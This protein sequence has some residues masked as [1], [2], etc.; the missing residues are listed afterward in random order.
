MD[1]GKHYRENKLLSR[2]ISLGMSLLLL[3][4]PPFERNPQQCEM[5]RV[6]GKR[7]KDGPPDD[8][9][10]FLKDDTYTTL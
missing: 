2:V 7:K 10:L 3:A 5:V 4:S 8:T 1:K 6:I 9:D